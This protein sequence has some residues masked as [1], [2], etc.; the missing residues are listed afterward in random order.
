LLFTSISLF[1][2]D[3]ARAQSRV[4]QR[5]GPAILRGRQLYIS[6]SLLVSAIFFGKKSQRSKTF[7][8]CLHPAFAIKQNDS[9][10]GQFEKPR[11]DGDGC[12]GC[13][14]S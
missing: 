5:H 7:T 12:A 9:T 1:D 4:H 6:R 13:Y 2:L 14:T 8:G 3:C 10:K 11:S